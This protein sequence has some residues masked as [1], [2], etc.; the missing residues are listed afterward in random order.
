MFR[1]ALHQ[2]RSAARRETRRAEFSDRVY[3]PRQDRRGEYV[4]PHQEL[5]TP[6]IPDMIRAALLF[7]SVGMNRKVLVEHMPRFIGPALSMRE[8][9][10]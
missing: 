10:V 9:R 7:G 3:H 5:T 2:K 4:G 8:G 1:S 6:F